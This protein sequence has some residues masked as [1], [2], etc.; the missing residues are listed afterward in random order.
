VEA[1]TA[2]V[3]TVAATEAV[4]DEAMAIIMVAVESIGTTEAS[5]QSS[6]PSTPSNT[7][8]N[9]SAGTGGATVSTSII[10][11]SVTAVPAA[12][13][14]IP[15]P[16]VSEPKEPTVESTPESKSDRPGTSA[17]EDNGIIV[18]AESR[19][20]KVNQTTD[21][22]P[23]SESKPASESK[24]DTRSRFRRRRKKLVADGREQ[25][26]PDRDGIDGY[27]ECKGGLAASGTI[28]TDN[29]DENDEWT[30]KKGRKGQ[31]PLY[32]RKAF[33]A[34]PKTIT[35]STNP[36]DVIQEED[37]EEE[38]DG[39]EGSGGCMMIPGESREAPYPPLQGR[40]GIGTMDGSQCDDKS[41]KDKGTK[42]LKV[43]AFNINSVRR[44]AQHAMEI[45]RT[46]QPD[47]L[48]LQETKVND[49]EF[50]HALIDFATG[51]GYQVY[52]RGQKQQLGVALFTKHQ[53]QRITFYKLRADTWR[54]PSGDSLSSGSMHRSVNSSVR[55][56]TDASA[57]S[58]VLCTS[59][60]AHCR[61]MGT[62][63]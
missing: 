54:P 9:G 15:E 16:E 4:V 61:I 8:G 57:S 20:A 42:D 49:E 45:L 32:S 21:I 62:W 3:A 43:M 46:E 56:I 13:E 17:R 1:S 34:R 39:S 47:I 53:P 5:Q 18:E 58:T 31:D 59:E 25:I 55:S 11:Q 26:L 44:R 35:I 41:S 30:I 60:S 37:C 19:S 22:R 38:D 23:S 10:I 51:L 27:E 29:G 24:S 48:F 40:E 52:F 33:T 2:A 14:P 6:A 12:I 50:P 36:Y 7:G 28:T 63:S